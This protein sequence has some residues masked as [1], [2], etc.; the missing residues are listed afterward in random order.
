M[1]RISFADV[2]HHSVVFSEEDQAEALILKLV[3]TPWIQRLR[4]VSQTANT[5][6]VY[7]FSEHSRF[8]HCLGVAHMA[9]SLMEKLSHTYPNEIKQYRT[10]IAAAAILHDVGHLAPGSHIAQKVWFPDHPDRHEEL[11]SKIISS[12][13]TITGLLQEVDPALPKL[14]GQILDEDDSLPPWTWEVI[15]GGGWNVDRGNW[16]IVDSVM[17][18]VAYG[19]YNIPAL[20]ESI[21]IS[22][23]GHLALRENRVD[24]MLHFAVSRHAMYRQIYQ[25]RV[26]LA[27][28][29]LTKAIVKRARDLGE[30]FGF[31]DPHMATALA[32]QSLD[33]L[34]I[35][36]AFWMREAWWRYHIYQWSQSDDGILAD[37][38]SRYLN[39]TLFK[40]VRVQEDEDVEELLGKAEEAVRKGGFDPAYYL[41]HAVAGDVHQGDS[42]Q[43]MLVRQIDGRL[44]PLSEA[45]PLFRTLINESETANRS[46]LVMP[47]EAKKLF[48]RER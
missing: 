23:N 26:L 17:A 43:S 29:Q 21:V 33:D 48:G 37:L 3:D 39:R 41:H 34:P 35:E 5:R 10:A 18:G 25:H 14:V 32:A 38:C 2:V 47:A 36:A 46:W 8:G 11:A 7:M 16:C 40:T 6:L 4:D 20:T 28:D 31:V 45:E 19:K 24:A 42:R 12:D 15:S 30:G 44:E 9:C 22:D 27:A 1:G 13:E